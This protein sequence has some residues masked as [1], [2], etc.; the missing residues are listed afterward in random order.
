MTS[1]IVHLCYEMFYH[2]SKGRP[3]GLIF[4]WKFHD[5][6]LIKFLMYLNQLNSCNREM[7]Q[8]IFSA[9]LQTVMCN[10]DEKLLV[11]QGDIA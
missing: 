3:I 6:H 7:E 4:S 8:L 2:M 5:K 1:S 11:H 9:L 10:C